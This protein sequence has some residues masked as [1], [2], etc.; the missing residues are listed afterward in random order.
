VF[1]A[2]QGT[3]QQ[4]YAR[5]LG[6]LEAT[7]LQGSDGASSPFFSPD[8]QWIGFW[9]DG[10][11]KKVPIGGGGATTLCETPT[12]FGASWG[13]NDL[14]VFANESGGLRQVSAAGGT[15]V[16]LTQLD[17]KAGE[18]SHRLPH[19]LPGNGAVMFTVTRTLLP[20]WDDTQVV[21]QPVAGGARTVLMEGAADGRYVPTGHLVYARRGT[22]NAAPFDLQQLRVT[23]GG[24]VTI[25]P[26]LMQSANMSN[27]AIDS[28]AGQFSVSVSGSLA[29]VRGGIYVFPERALVWVDRAGKV[30]ALAAPPRAY[31]YPRLSADGSEILVSTQGDRN[32]WLYNIVR[33]TTTRLTV[34]GRNM[35]AIW[36]PD[37]KRVTFGSSSGGQENLFWKPAN[38]SGSA[39]RLTDSPRLQRASAWSPD[40][41]A[42]AFVEGSAGAPNASD[43]MVL[44]PNGNRQS[45]P[46]FAT[47]FDEQ[48]PEFSPDGRWVAYASNESGRSEVYVAPYPGPGP[49]VA[50]SV[51]GGHSPAWTRNGRELVYL[52]P[53]GPDGSGPFRVTVVSVTTGQTF[54]S[55][56]PRVLFETPMGLQAAVRGYDIT[57]DG[58]RFLMVQPRPRPPITPSRIVLVQHWFDELRRRVP[59]Q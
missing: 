50:V 25:V 39:E 43:V 56:T 21:V 45:H 59:T 6:Q 17:I 41:Q 47:R 36:T 14:I 3:R 12:L 10:A 23:G 35:A 30:E 42:L 22:L 24:S 57:A 16:A 31:N 29:Y 52:S 46:L 38:G 58:A 51:E 15:A 11:L 18:V 7:P 34:D 19:I 55:G 28:G 48:Y 1:S 53:L 44:T 20:T 5:P 32:V 33:G 54:V 37:G 9:A 2:V 49:K 4:L 40:G 27:T 26:D 8:G 13:S